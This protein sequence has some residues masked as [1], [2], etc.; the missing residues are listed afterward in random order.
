MMERGVTSRVSS[1]VMVLVDGVEYRKV[2]VPPVSS[3]VVDAMGGQVMLGLYERAAVVVLL[4]ADSVGISNK[5][6]DHCSKD[7]PHQ[8]PIPT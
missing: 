1:R 2:G 4:F 6:H 3:V 8:A 7:N 5:Q